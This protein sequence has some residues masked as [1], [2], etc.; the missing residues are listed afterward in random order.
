MNDNID[1]LIGMANQIGSF[2]ETQP[3]REES[4]ASIANHIRNFWE[5]RMRVSLLTFLEQH[6]DGASGNTALTPFTLE[7]I[8]LHKE[9]LR[10]RT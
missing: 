3:E 10:P 8:R 7:A 6:P 9:R 5:P 1:T 2:F 4:L